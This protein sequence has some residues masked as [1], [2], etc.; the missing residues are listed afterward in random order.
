M[1][2]DQV[3]PFWEK[4]TLTIQEASD[5]FRIGEKKLRKLVDNNKNSNFI[6]WNGNRPQIKR[7]KFE[8]YVDDKL[9]AI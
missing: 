2:N 4:Y 1:K 9:N 6:M 5:Y 7:R 8:Q 3:I